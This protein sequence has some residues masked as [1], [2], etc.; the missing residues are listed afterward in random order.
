MALTPEQQAEA[1]RAALNAFG[2]TVLNG[3][4]KLGAAFND[5]VTMPV[6]GVAGAANTLLRVPNAYGAGIP[7]IPDNGWLTS[8]TPYSDR[9]NASAPLPAT[10]AGAGRGMVN[11]PNADTLAQVEPVQA[12]AKATPATQGTKKA[13]AAT[14]PPPRDGQPMQPALIPGETGFYVGDQLV[15]YGTT[16]RVGG[17]G[18]VMQLNNFAS[19]PSSG[20]AGGRAP[21]SAMPAGAT[22]AV[23]YQ[24]ALIDP[25]AYFREAVAAQMSFAQRAA[26]AILSQAGS[27]SDLGYSA[28]LRALSSIFNNGLAA[29]GQGGANTFNSATASMANAST[30]A[31]ASDMASQR[32]LIGDLARSSA[33]VRAAELGADSQDY[34]HT[35]ADDR[36]YSTPQLAGQTMLP[37]VGG[38]PTPVPTYAMPQRRAMPKAVTNLG[39]EAADGDRGMAPGPGGAM[40]PVV[41]KNGKWVADTGK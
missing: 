16:F 32:H 34:A 40:V 7:F 27:G 30:S 13:G 41:R 4:A 3:G 35:L 11:P 29:V 14:P 25:R 15:P 31:A 8:M 18:G 19:T 21:T 23:P 36:F 17:D 24:D 33:T 12:A 1:D 37:G 2:Q 26:D 38:I 5:I 10:G 28:R 20:G 6:R 22:G 39:P 9:L